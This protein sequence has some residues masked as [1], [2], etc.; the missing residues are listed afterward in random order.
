MSFYCV[1]RTARKNSRTGYR[2][3]HRIANIGGGKENSRVSG[4]RL[5][6]KVANLI[7]EEG[8]D[9]SLS[10][11][12]DGVIYDQTMERTHDSMYSFEPAE[13]LK[14]SSVFN[15]HRW[16]SSNGCGMVPQASPQSPDILSLLQQQ[17]KLLSQ[18]LTEQKEI[19][20]AQKN[21]DKRV[22][23]ME[24]QINSVEQSVTSSSCSSS[25]S[26]SKKQHRRITRDLTV[27]DIRR[28]L[29]DLV[30]EL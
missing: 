11:K 4:N 8:D 13:V 21:F 17:Q 23:S 29:A 19:K 15:S 10:N 24:Q 2:F 9:E 1:S 14:S 7:S 25:P 12:E 16:P 6:S 30:C 27:S 28:Y 20:E 3:D 5:L 22:S 18:V 26:S